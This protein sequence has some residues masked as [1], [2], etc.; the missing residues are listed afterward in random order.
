MWIFE[1]LTTHFEHLTSKQN[2]E[3]DSFISEDFTLEVLF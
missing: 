2:T 3:T 1:K